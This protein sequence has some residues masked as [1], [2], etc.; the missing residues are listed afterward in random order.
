MVRIPIICSMLIAASFCAPGAYAQQPEPIKWTLLQ[1][2][3]FPGDKI[4]T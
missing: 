3:D 4:A 2:G 1:R